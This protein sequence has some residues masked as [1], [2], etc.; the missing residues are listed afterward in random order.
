MSLDIDLLKSSFENVKPIAG[1]VADK[2]YELLWGN[3]QG[4]DA[5]F[6]NANMENQKKLL[7]KIGRAHV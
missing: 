6:A 5:L 1:Q 7:I 2:F 3:Y 4:S